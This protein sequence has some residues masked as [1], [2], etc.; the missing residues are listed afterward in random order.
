M[1]HFTSTIKDPW[2]I[3]HEL[4]LQ[5]N[6]NAIAHSDTIYT[7]VVH[8]GFDAD[9]TAEEL[10]RRY[11]AFEETEQHRQFL[12]RS[13]SERLALP[14][15]CETED[16]F[17]P[18]QLWEEEDRLNGKRGSLEKEEVESSND[19][20]D[21]DEDK[22]SFSAAPIVETANDADL[23]ITL[24]TGDHTTTITRDSADVQLLLSTLETSPAVPLRAITHCTADGSLVLS[25][26]GHLPPTP[27]TTCTLRTTEREEPSCRD[28]WT[29]V[30]ECPQSPTVAFF[31]GTETCS[32]LLE[33]I[34]WALDSIVATSL[35]Y[36][37]GRVLVVLVGEH[38]DLEA[39][40]Y[41]ISTRD[42][43]P[44]GEFEGFFGGMRREEE[45]PVEFAELVGLLLVAERDMVEVG[46]LEGA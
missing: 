41:G 13:L 2:D 32:D 21:E 37:D 5:L 8:K 43:D 18:E 6:P 16:Y 45:V 40:P 33:E 14:G 42:G 39:N 25:L 15:G 4:F 24:R 31:S 17:T 7:G 11:P 38:V 26:L 29:V 34:A 10:V 20:E 22:E 23:A 1:P 19:E 27:T 30:S 9:S 12:V 35:A 3:E 36:D 28:E 46:A 44:A